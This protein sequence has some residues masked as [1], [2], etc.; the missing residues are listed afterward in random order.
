MRRARLWSKWVTAGGTALLLSA[1]ASAPRDVSLPIS[2]PNELGPA[3]KRAVAMVKSGQ[4]ALVDV[5][6]DPR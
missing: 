3:L 4:P 5:I 1:C 6:T 2:D